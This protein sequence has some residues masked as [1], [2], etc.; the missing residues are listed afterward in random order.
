M[1][2]LVVE[3][4]VRLADALGQILK[5]Q[6]YQVDVV[7]DGRDGYD[8]G[9][10]GQ[11]DV[12]VLDVMLP[13]MDGFQVVNKLRKE[14]IKTPVLMLTAKDDLRNKIQ[15]LDSGADDYMT[16]PFEPEE[17]LARIRA[18]S[19]RLGEVVLDELSFD[20]LKLNLSTADL[21]CT[22][23]KKGKSVHLGFKEFEVL[24]LLMA[25]SPNAVSK[26]DLIT[27]VWGVESSAEDN[28]VE[29]YISFL[30]K[31]FFFIGSRVQIGTLRRV[32]YR[33]E[34]PENA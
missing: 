16:K 15:G 13:Y 23:P 22:N 5:E 25:N 33:L 7:Y 34:V 31:K 6:R 12:I 2:I 4:E 29:A 21:S 30:R 3:D 20:D 32:G 1:N 27:K 28:N 8:Y 9:V 19:R 17:L 18:L 11:Y 14:H 24:K 26:D 10:S